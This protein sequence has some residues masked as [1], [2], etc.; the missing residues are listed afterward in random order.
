MY[1][2]IA[3][4]LLAVAAAAI[5]VAI[6]V[7]VAWWRG[8]ATPVTVDRLAA[9]DRQRL[10][11]EL[12]EVSPGALQWAWFEPRIGY[13]LAPGAELEIWGDRFTANEIGY[14]SGAVTTA[15]GVFRVLF[16]GDSWTYGMGVAEQ[17]GFPAA[18]ARLAGERLG[19]EA[20]VEAATL[21]LPGYNGFNQ[22]AALWY[23]FDR[24]EPDAVVLCPC[25]NDHNSTYTILPNGSIWEGGVAR[26]LFGHPH[27]IWFRVRGADS[28]LY[29][30][31]RAAVFAAMA[32]TERRLAAL[33]VPLFTLYIADWLDEEVHASVADAG[34]RSP[35]AVVPGRFLEG[36]WLNPP[37]LLHG[38]PAANALYGAIAYRGLAGVLGWPADDLDPAALEA[39]IHTAP[40]ADVDWQLRYSERMR[41]DTRAI[42]AEYRPGPQ[43][44]GQCSGALDPDTGV[45]GRAATVL[46]R[47]PPGATTLEVVV[48]RL[49]DARSLYPLT[50]AVTV[51]GP[52]DDAVARLEVPAAGDPVRRIS[53][54]L[55]ADS[56]Q[57]T[58][59]DV[60]LEV[61]RVVSPGDGL[62][63]R[64]LRLESLT[65]R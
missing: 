22:L 50:L 63:A 3:R 17:D 28:W 7:G 41:Q 39:P 64:S 19:P 2:R 40:P 53:V 23:F 47:R 11:A 55:P 49:G 45:L 1:E 26:D 6:A 8:R 27:G 61:D 5:A 16:V 38:T 46:L 25:S 10:V 24:L 56:G 33:G 59:L 42:P 57:H 13:T 29:R 58:A 34:L 44:R 12:F 15:D 54:E 4:I 62:T 48:R 14:R 20:R 51:P 18:F 21:A 9:A 30:S 43:A 36:A 35:Y 60:V 32:D 65:L 37:P 31:R 52:T